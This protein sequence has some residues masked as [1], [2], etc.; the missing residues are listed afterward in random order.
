MATWTAEREL[1]DE[2]EPDSRRLSRVCKIDFPGV[3]SSFSTSSCVKVSVT[4]FK[5]S[6]HP[7]TAMEELMLLKMTVEE[8]K[9]PSMTIGTLGGLVKTG[10]DGCV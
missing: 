6:K 10:A 1:Q 2:L 7:D 8:V 4:C 5:P 9:F 3:F